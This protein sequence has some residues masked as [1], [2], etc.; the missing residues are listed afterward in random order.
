MA[1]YYE[2]TI[3][4]QII[5]DADMTPLERLLL[6]RVFESERIDDGWYFFA[7]E[8]P[9]SMIYATRAELEQALSSSPDIESTAHRGIVGR[10][11]TASDTDDIEIDSDLN[12]T[13]WERFFQDI[14]K[15]LQD[16]ALYHRHHRIH[17]HQDAP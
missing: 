16:A 4:Q 13:C 12:D 15:T 8:S 7:E 2:Q 1:D 10:L 11:L 3:V 9:C 5:P 14:V 17:L 6:S